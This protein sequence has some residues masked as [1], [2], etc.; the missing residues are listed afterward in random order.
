LAARFTQ[1]YVLRIISDVQNA[2][3]QIEKIEALVDKL[4]T[5]DQFIKLVLNKDAKNM[6]A[7]IKQIA[8]EAGLTDDQ[9]K[10]L[11][12]TVSDVAKSFHFLKRN[13]NF[14]DVL[15]QK[16]RIEDLKKSLSSFSDIANKLNFSEGIKSQIASVAESFKKVES[17]TNDLI[18]DCKCWARSINITFRRENSCLFKIRKQ[19]LERYTIRHG[20][21]PRPRSFCKT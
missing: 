11:T 1:D 18:N 10:L 12:K 6:P 2:S 13:I 14:N 4:V 7:F 21:N 16:D 20:T 19:D 17:G 3:T 8:T 15:S 9:F 5:R